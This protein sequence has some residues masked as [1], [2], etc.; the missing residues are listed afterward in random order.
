MRSDQKYRLL[1]EKRGHEE[2]ET[3]AQI[4]AR[5]A[6]EIRVGERCGRCRLLRPCGGHEELT[7]EF[8]AQRRTGDSMGLGNLP[9]TE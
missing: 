7:I 1:R 9:K 6:R 2:T 4:D 3:P 8:H 5:N